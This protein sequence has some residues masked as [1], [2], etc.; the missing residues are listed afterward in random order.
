L[1]GKLEVA[2]GT[3]NRIDGSSEGASQQHRGGVEGKSVEAADPP[4]S[5][6]GTFGSVAGRSPVVEAVTFG[7]GEAVF[8]GPETTIV[9]DDDDGPPPGSDASA[10]AGGGGGGDEVTDDRETGDAMIRVPEAT[11]VRDDDEIVYV[12]TPTRRWHD[13]RQTKIMFGLFFLFLAALSTG[14]GVGLIRAIPDDDVD[15]DVGIEGDDGGST[16]P[17][18]ISPSSSSAAFPPSGSSPPSSPATCR[19]GMMSSAKKVDAGA[20][21]HRDSQC[22]WMAVDG[23]NMVRIVRRDGGGGDGGGGDGD[24]D[25]DGDGGGGWGSSFDVFFL[26]R[27]SSSNENGEWEHVNTLAVDDLA[28]SDDYGCHSIS[29][30][31]SGNTAF[32]GFSYAYDERGAVFVYERKDPNATSPLFEDVGGG[33]GGGATWVMAEDPFVHDDG[34]FQ[35]YFGWHVNVDGD[36]ACVVDYGSVGRVNIFRRDRNVVG[37]D[38][39]TE[40]KWV[41]VNTTD[42]SWC[43]ISGN[44]IAMREWDY[45]LWHE[46]LRF[47]A[48]DDEDI[49]GRLA[50]IQEPIPV[51]WM[52]AMELSGDYLVYSDDVEVGAFV[53]RRGNGSNDRTYSLVQRLDVSHP[54]AEDHMTLD[55]DML[56]IGGS[57]NTTHILSLRGDGMWVETMTLDRMYENYQLSGRVLLAGNVDEVYSF[58]IP[59][60]AR[61]FPT[62]SPVPTAHPSSSRMPTRSPS[63]SMVPTVPPSLSPAPT[64]SSNPS[65]TP[66]PSSGPSSSSS[67]TTC[68]H[69]I[70]SRAQKIDIPLDDPQY[71]EVVIDGR[72]MVLVVYNGDSGEGQSPRL[73]GGHRLIL[74][75]AL[76]DDGEWQVVSTFDFDIDLGVIYSAALSGRTAFVGFEDANN[77]AGIV[78][79]YE[80]N[81]FGE[82][83]K[84]EDLYSSNAS[85]KQ[86]GS[87]VDINGDFACVDNIYNDYILLYRRVN[88][89]W[90]Q[91]DDIEGDWCSISEDLL[92]TAIYNDTD[93]ASPGSLHLFEYSKDPDG[94]VSIQ[95]PILAGF[96]KVTSTKLSGDYLVYLDLREEAAFI[97]HRGGV[98]Q[99]YSFQQRIVFPDV[100]K[101]QTHS[102]LAIYNEI[103]AIRGIDHIHIFSLQNGKWEDGITLNQTSLYHQLDGRTL[104]TA[105]E[106]EVFSFTIED[107]AFSSP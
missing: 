1:S 18:G 65:M 24:G 66:S 94:I 104:L 107:C 105:T 6:P 15:D 26:S 59:S 57:D 55:D 48:Y 99:T 88:D 67:P 20:V 39:T 7:L 85:V 41:H 103:I 43:Q 78:H 3:D 77:K 33:G 100:P 101:T 37:D 90:V 95:V 62:P 91:V 76:A 72:N 61:D 22:P 80:Q 38:D 10:G 81:L 12:A 8:F 32:V 63:P 36:M 29:V 89:E 106:N 25:G 4:S 86:F 75:Y 70:V 74:F 60:C 17:G 98:N 50:S 58:D 35:G 46:Y 92:V 69:N 82:W 68:A 53:Y 83:E 102:G 79:I 44:T 49:I 87:H 23:S 93:L 40:K 30:S 16:R 84:V 34:V 2:S 14:L 31:M 21:P 56:V 51:E 71:P 9:V 11:L 97:Y 45:E 54:K 5:S 73:G 52:V 96:F 19:D 47:Y 27:R 13:Q 64:S 28:I 42:G